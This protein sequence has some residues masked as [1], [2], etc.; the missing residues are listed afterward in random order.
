MP[1]WKEAWEA[2]KQ[3]IVDINKLKDERHA[4]KQTALVKASSGKDYV[5][6]LKRTAQNKKKG[7][8]L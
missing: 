2:I 1:S 6:K 5:S 3:D 8:A 4:I 7:S